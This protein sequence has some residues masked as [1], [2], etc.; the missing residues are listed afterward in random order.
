MLNELLPVVKELYRTT[1]RIPSISDESELNLDLLYATNQM[2]FYKVF[3]LDLTQEQLTAG[4]YPCVDYLEKCFWS[5]CVLRG[6]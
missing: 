3:D 4:L 1:R 2:C 6:R 5:T